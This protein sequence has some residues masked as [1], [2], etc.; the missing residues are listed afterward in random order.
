MNGAGQ[1]SGRGLTLLGVMLAAGMVASTFIASRGIE[2]IKL[3]NQ[4]IRVKGSSE[5]KIVSDW[6]VWDA[7]FAARAPGLTAAYEKIR[8]DLEAVLAYLEKNGVPRGTV[9][10][11]SVSTTIQHK[12]NEK[13]NATNVIEGYV[14][15]QSIQLKSADIPLVVRL[16]RD[17]TSL[18]QQ[19]IEFSSSPPNYYYTKLNDLKISM[20]GEATKDAKARA[21]QLA[22]N[23]GCKVGALRSASQGVFQITSEYSTEVSDY[24]VYDTGSVNK[25]VKALV[26][27][28]FSIR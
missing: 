6:A 13:G 8:Q 9:G 19:G 5:R 4:T 23:S 7:R 24:G 26:T 22:K 16:A 10:V 11:S 27:M 17:S 18:I 2:R 20:L 28:E 15:E 1:G 12:P 25:C 14:L 3:A 21:E